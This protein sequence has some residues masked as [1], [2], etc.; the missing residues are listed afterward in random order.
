M[1]LLLTTGCTSEYNLTIDNNVYQE[2]VNINGI[3][4][5]E[6]SNLN[7]DWQIPYKRGA[8]CQ[9]NVRTREDSLYCS[10]SRSCR[11]GNAEISHLV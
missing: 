11:R 5:D 2:K 1:I 6:L 3:T 10:F 4:S 9:W 7:R 8:H